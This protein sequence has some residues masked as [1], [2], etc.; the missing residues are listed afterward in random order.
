MTDFKTETIE[1]TV[2]VSEVIRASVTAVVVAQEHDLT[3]LPR[4]LTAVT[5]QVLKPNKLILAVP[6]KSDLIGTVAQVARNAGAEIVEIGV[7]KNLGTALH[8]ALKEDAEESGSADATDRASADWLWI[9]HADSAPAEYTLDRLLRRAE[10]SARI[11]AV[12]PK[13]V[14]WADPA[15]EEPRELLEVGI[16]ATRTARRVP[17]IELDERDQGQLDARSDVLAVGT[18]GMLVRMSAYRKLGGLDPALGPFGDG[19]EFSRRLRHAGYR[20][21]VQTDALIYH[22][23]ASLGEAPEDSFAQRRAAQIYNALLAAPAGLL[24]LRV[25]GYILAAFPRALARTVMQQP[26]LARAELQAGMS[27]FAMRDNITT[28]RAAIAEINR[29][30]ARAL[31]GLED[32]AADV[33]AAQRESQRTQQENYLLATRPDPLVIKAKADLRR[34]TRRGLALTVL[35]AAVLSIVFNLQNLSQ[36]VLAGGQ[37][38]N[39]SLTA[40]GLWEILRTGWLSSGDGYPFAMD[41]LIITW[42]PIL[43]LGAPFGLNLGSLA[44]ILYYLAIPAAAAAGY[45]FAGRMTKSWVMR[46]VLGAVWA[47][48]PPLLT[49][50]AQGQ[51]AAVAVHIY[52][53][54]ASYAIIVAWRESFSY[55][56]LAALLSGLLVSAAPIFLPVVLLVTVIKLIS[57]GKKRLRWLW[58]PVPALVLLAPVLPYV[59]SYNFLF[60]TPLTPVAGPRT[61]REV[62]QLFFT[63]EFSTQ[64][65]WDWFLFSM[66]AVVLLCAILALLRHIRMWRVRIGWLV[67]LLG[68]TLALFATT[69]PVGIVPT[70][71]G[72]EIAPAWAGIGISVMWLGLVVAIGHGSY[73]LRTAINTRGFGSTLLLGGLAMVV[74]PIALIGG[75]AQWA[76]IQLTESGNIQPAGD[77]LPAIGHEQQKN[78]LR[79]LALEPEQGGVLAQLW[80]GPGPQI[81]EYPMLRS[82]AELDQIQAAPDGQNSDL[83]HQ[84]LAGAI[85]DLTAASPQVAQKLSEHAVSVVLLPPGT[86][87]ERGDFAAYLGTVP[88]LEYITENEAGAFWRV[89]AASMGAISDSGEYTPLDIGDTWDGGAGTLQLSERRNSGWEAKIGSTE[90]TA[91]G[92]GWAQ[93]WEIPADATGTIEISYSNPITYLNWIQVLGYLVSLIA[94]LPAVRSRRSVV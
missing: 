23:R 94:T 90:L 56:G 14:G 44:T 9:L 21:L 29:V 60:A 17:E 47:L 32:T 89:A 46:M 51:L 42:L 74:L 34:Y 81:H 16:R 10:S 33:R 92:D 35:L 50:L 20:V 58:L 79:V 28:G 5:A 68:F 93:T 30:P 1:M 18:A 80:R 55:L 57:P 31:R 12:G 38:A 49:A 13:Q 24:S 84:H 66:A 70:A 65:N 37:L 4:T 61:A 87:S 64:P 54:L 41:P 62:F 78:G 76:H 88:K 3:Y 43:I 59:R 36:G 85:A 91:T 27:V 52:L 11:G 45:I 73:G 86:S 19:L 40:G 75:A 82:L 53:P 72:Y 2:P 26:G 71:S 69:I 7:Q 6:A 39:D 22:A 83:A 15:V 8:A 77:P 25:V 63:R 67:A 48:A